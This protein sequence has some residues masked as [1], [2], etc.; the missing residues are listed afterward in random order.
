MIGWNEE[1]VVWLATL[2]WRIFDE[3]KL[4]VVLLAANAGAAGDELFEAADSVNFVNHIVTA[5]ER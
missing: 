3:Q 5:L 4:A 2:G 1:C